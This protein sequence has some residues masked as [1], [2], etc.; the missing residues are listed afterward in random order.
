MKLFHFIFFI[1]LL[2]GIYGLSLGRCG[3]NVSCP[4]G[5]CCSA[6]GY[7]GV[8]SEHCGV[9]CQIQYCT[10]RINRISTD[11]R[12][13]PNYDGKIC[14]NGQCCSIYGWCGTDHEF[15]GKGCLKNYGQCSSPSSRANSDDLITH[16]GRC[17]D[18]G[19]RCPNGQCCSK[20][21]WCGTGS[22]FCGTGCQSKFGSCDGVDSPFVFG[23]EEEEEE[24]GEGD[25]DDSTP[26]KIKIFD[27]CK[28]DNQWALTFDDGPFQYDEDLLDFLKSVDAK[29]T[30]FL[31]GN[32]AM[33]I[34]SK[35]GRN[36]VKRIH[37]EGHE[38]GSHTYNHVDLNNVTDKEFI[39]Q[40]RL[41]EDALEDII[42]VKPSFLRPP[43]GSYYRNST[44]TETLEY[45][46]Y[47]GIIMWNVDTLDWNNDGS[48]D[49]AISQF[50]NSLGKPI[51]SLNHS[52]YKNITKEKL[53][54]LVKVEIEY[55]KR[56]GYKM[57]TMSECVGLEAYQ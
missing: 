4:P 37:D 45:L 14:P 35:T 56:K 31:N 3:G 2:S 26:S 17:G 25:N 53:I 51:I 50:K 29:A 12:C 33:D 24:E 18:N 7:C 13:G 49:Y 57:V 28:H 32:N 54:N 27:R 46:G 30:F 48:I 1:P 16:D 41:L 21:G 11:G 23:E 43:Y 15:C 42:G 19:R 9:G 34:T 38:I 6:F 52:F 40:I 36:I 55:M 47:T 10:C 8:T 44:V 39:D 20:Y 5:Y 22:S